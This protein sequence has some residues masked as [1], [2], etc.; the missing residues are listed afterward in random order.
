MEVDTLEVSPDGTTIASGSDDRTVITWAI[1]PMAAD[2][3]WV[4]LG[5][6]DRINTLSISP[7]GH[8]LASSGED[9]HVILWNMDTAERVG[10]PIPVVREPVP[11]VR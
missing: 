4:I 10:D 6:T 5:H 11:R 7:D 1:G 8:W 3:H 9:E 2:A